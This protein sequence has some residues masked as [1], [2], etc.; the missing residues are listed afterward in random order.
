M[1]GAVSLLKKNVKDYNELLLF[2]SQLAN[3]FVGLYEKLKITPKDPSKKIPFTEKNMMPYRTIITTETKNMRKELRNFITPT[4]E[5]E[6]AFPLVSSPN[7]FH[8]SGKKTE[9]KVNSAKK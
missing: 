5:D 6:L 2:S 8:A 3:N 7:K 1:I 9:P 4:N